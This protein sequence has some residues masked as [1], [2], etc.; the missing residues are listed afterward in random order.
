MW[1][2]FGNAMAISDILNKCNFSVKKV[3]H[4]SFH[5]TPF[6]LLVDDESFWLCNMKDIKTYILL[7]FVFC[8]HDLHV[9]F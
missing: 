8:V 7:D 4:S 9:S 3:S 2:I 1:C 5:F 6:C